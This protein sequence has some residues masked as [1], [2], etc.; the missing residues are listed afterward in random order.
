MIKIAIRV[1]VGK[2]NGRLRFRHK[3]PQILTLLL[4]H[5]PF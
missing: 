1:F 4:D 5:K 3:I 2:Q